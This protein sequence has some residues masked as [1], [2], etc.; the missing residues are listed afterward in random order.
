MVWVN[1]FEESCV[2][3]FKQVNFGRYD[4]PTPDVFSQYGH[5]KFVAS[6]GLQIPD[7]EIDAWVKKAIPGDSGSLAMFVMGNKLVAAGHYSQ[8]AAGTWFGQ[9]RNMNDLNRMIKQLDEIG[10]FDTKETITEASMRRYIDL[11]ADT[12]RSATEY[13]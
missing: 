12:S 5:A 8:P 3:T 4:D 1:Q 13:R 7:P 2:G 10:G 11:K 9:L 6:F